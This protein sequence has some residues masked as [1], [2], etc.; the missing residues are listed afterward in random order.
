MSVG[1][2][3]TGGAEVND[4]DAL[5]GNFQFRGAGADGVLV[6]EKDGVSDFFIHQDVAGAENLVVVAFGENDA[7]GF[8]LSFVNDGAGDLV[9]S[10][11]AALELLAV[12]IEIDRFLSDTA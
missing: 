1:I 10:A 9:R 12:I 7:H 11:E 5:E 2:A 4:A 6:A 3:K 8:H